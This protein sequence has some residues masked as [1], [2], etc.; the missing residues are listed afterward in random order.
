MMDEL[1]YS[2]IRFDKTTVVSLPGQDV[3]SSV[4]EAEYLTLIQPYVMRV[5]GSERKVTRSPRM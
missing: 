3:D 1:D 4:V 2:E 5:E